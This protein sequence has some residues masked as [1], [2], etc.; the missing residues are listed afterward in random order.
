MTKQYVEAIESHK[1]DRTQERLRGICAWHMLITIQTY[2]RNRN[3]Q[4]KIPEN[5]SEAKLGTT[6]TIF[7]N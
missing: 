7:V 4:R 5:L 1:T 6:S 2:G 3:P